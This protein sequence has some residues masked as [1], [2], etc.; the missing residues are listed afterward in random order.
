MEGMA[1]KFTPVT[2][3]H[4]LGHLSMF[5]LMAGTSWTHSYIVQTVL[6]NDS[7]CMPLFPDH[8]AKYILFVVT[9][10]LGYKCFIMATPYLVQTIVANEAPGTGQHT[11][12]LL[13]Y[14]CTL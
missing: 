11:I 3:R 6:T 4:L 8:I 10:K 13:D 7:W 2:V 5:G 12:I 9:S 1:L 14:W